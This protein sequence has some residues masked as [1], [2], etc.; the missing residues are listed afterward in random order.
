MANVK[1]LAD[2]LSELSIKNSGP[3]TGSSTSTN[4]SYKL[5]SK[6]Q[7]AS[8]T[9]S[10]PPPGPVF[11]PL[12]EKASSSTLNS[13]NTKAKSNVETSETP[14]NHNQDTLNDIGAY[15]GGFENEMDGG[16]GKEVTGEAAE[17]LALDSSTNR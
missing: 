14:S 13:A 12:K 16:R 7:G 9:T 8:G 2:K 4:A 1:S 17:E 11:K 6:Y 10:R 5:Q 15:D 3:S